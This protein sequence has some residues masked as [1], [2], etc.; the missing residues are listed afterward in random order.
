MSFLMYLSTQLTIIMLPIWWSVPWLWT[1]FSGPGWWWGYVQ[2]TTTVYVCRDGIHDT[3]FIE[4]HEIAHHFWFKLLTQEERD[5]YEVLFKKHFEKK[6]AFYREYS[7][8]N[9]WEDFADNF[10]IIQW[11][12][13]ISNFFHRQRINFIKKLIKKYDD[14]RFVK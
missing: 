2:E 8:T 7:K 1:C 13:R 10:A 3:T 12:W 6:N 14:R 5:Q 4:N 9:P 11:Q